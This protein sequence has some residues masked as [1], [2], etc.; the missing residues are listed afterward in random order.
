[1]NQVEVYIGGTGM[2]GDALRQPAFPGTRV[3]DNERSSQV[4]A[5]QVSESLP[6]GFQ[7]VRAR[8]SLRSGGI[9]IFPL[10]EQRPDSRPSMRLPCLRS[11][12]SQTPVAA[13]REPPEPHAL[14]PKRRVTRTTRN[15]PNR[16]PELYIRRY[17]SSLSRA[18]IQR[19]RRTAPA[20]RN[21]AAL[22]RQPEPSRIAL[23][24]AGAMTHNVQ[25][26]NSFAIRRT[27]RRQTAHAHGVEY[28]MRSS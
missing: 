12:Q 18:E 15:Q 2:D 27:D 19:H 20:P 5:E 24:F 7:S 8:E 22:S 26:E 6:A 13:V 3:S 11:R 21:A 25:P 10:P 28:G 14:R 1:M 17:R 4:H 23:A 16:D 9:R